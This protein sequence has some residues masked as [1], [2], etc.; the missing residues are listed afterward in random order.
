MFTLSPPFWGA[1]EGDPYWSFVKTL[2][3]FDGNYIDSSTAALPYSASGAATITT[4]GQRYGSGALDCTASNGA[5]CAGGGAAAVMGSGDFCIECW[6]KDDNQ[7]T[8]NQ[9][10]WLT[11]DVAFANT[12]RIYSPSAGNLS[13]DIAG[14]GPAGS[15][16][17]SY[18]VWNHSALT[19]SG[20]NWTHWFNGVAAQTWVNSTYNTG[21][22]LNVWV[23]SGSSGGSGLMATI[24][25]FRITIGVPRYTAP[26]TPSGPFPNRGL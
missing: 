20:N 10:L 24:D 21:S 18:G 3:H 23:G 14:A 8:K 2:L 22:S 6:F 25:E 9:Y 5:N 16:A 15:F 26:F 4:S 1:E 11:Q 19:R 7:A 13:A 17:Y 12:M